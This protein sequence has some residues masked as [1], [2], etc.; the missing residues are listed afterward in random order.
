MLPVILQ[1]EPLP[2]AEVGAAV[3]LLSVL[4]TVVWLIY[5]YR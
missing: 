1:S 4:I 3:L 2:V 5:L